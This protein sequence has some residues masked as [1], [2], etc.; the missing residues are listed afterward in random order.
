V[1]GQTALDKL[2]KRIVANQT[3]RTLKHVNHIIAPSSKTRDLL[4]SY[5]VTNPLSIIP[6]GVDLDRFSPPRKDDENRLVHLREKYGT[7]KFDHTLLMIGRIAPEKSVSKLL[8]M[9]IPY[10]VDHPDTCLL[11][12][13]DGPSLGELIGRAQQ[14]GLA[15]QVLFTGEIAW[16]MVPDFY[17]ISDALIGN[18]H[19][20]TQ[21][22]TF[23]EAVAT[24][25]PVVA[26]YN[27]CLDGILTDGVDASLF[28]A[29]SQFIPALAEALDP[30]KRPDR[31]EA[32]LVAARA[33]SKAQ[34]V[35]RVESVY[36][37]LISK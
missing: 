14:V 11:I 24:G 20:E 33:I 12:V 3:R 27:A 29:E 26:R 17:R 22:L 37:D 16:E 8:D 15:S 28:T 25:V 31:I 4:T 5:G 32:G 7:D 13:G 2:A 36:L 9:T 21:G 34:F 6:T 10:L 35:D 30:K 23:I 18:S 19:T 1:T